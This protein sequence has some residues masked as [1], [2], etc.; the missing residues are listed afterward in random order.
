MT[1]KKD[2]KETRNS[3]NKENKDKRNSFP[4]D[5]RLQGE[6]KSKKDSEKD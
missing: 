2:K 1:R 4:G 6:A 5:T 3:W